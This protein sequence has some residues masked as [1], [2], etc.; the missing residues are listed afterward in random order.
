[1]SET[2]ARRK[3]RRAAEARGLVVDFIEWQ[4]ISAGPEMSGAAGGWYVQFDPDGHA[5]G[6]NLDEVL[7]WIGD[8]EVPGV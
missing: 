7:E 2:R 6:L 3:I 5:L 8:L 1:M 4:P